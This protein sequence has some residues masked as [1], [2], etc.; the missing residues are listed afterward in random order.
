M[1]RK[2]GKKNEIKIDPLA[3]NICL[4][5]EP[6]IGK[7]QPIS[8]PVLL[9][10][11]WTPMGDVKVGDKI[12]GQDGKMYDVTG[13]FPQGVKDVYEITFSD[14]TKTRCGIEHLW[15]VHTKKQREN[16]RKNGDYRFVVKSLEEIIKDYKKEHQSNPYNSCHYKYSVPINSE[17]EFTQVEKLP[18]DPYILGLLLGDGGFTGS[19]VTF[20]S[21]E[22]ELFNQLEEELKHMGL[23]L[24][25]RDF[26]NH[27][28][29]T[30]IKE[31][32]NNSKNNILNTLLSELNLFGCDSRQKF[33]P[34]Q[35]I[36]S[37]IENRIKILSGIINTD[38]HIHEGISIYVCSYSEKLA[39]DV[40]ELARSLGFIAIFGNWDRTNES[41]TRKY[42]NEIEYRVTIIGDYSKLHLS[43]KHK[44][45]LKQRCWEYCKSIIDIQLVGQEESQCIMV[46]NPSNLYITNDYIV[47]H[48]TTIVKEMLEKLVGENGYMFLEMAGEAGADAISSIVYEDIDDWSDLEDI[49]EDIEY[50]KTTDYADLKAIV[51]DTYDGW[52]KL[53]EK[54]AIRLWNKNHPDKKADSIDA[55]WSGFQKGQS[56]AFE[57]MF[58][59]MVRLKK[60]GVSMIIIGHVKNKELT[61]I[62]TGIAYQT[63]TSDVE[64]IYFNLLKKKMHF[65][66]LAFYDR[67]I[68]TEKTGKKNI[69]TKKDETKNKVVEES[70]KI[71]F[72]DDNMALDSGSRFADI[73]EEIPL[74]SD[75]L[76]NALQDAIRA[77]HS[78]QPTTKSI[79]EV[80]KEQEIAKEQIV[81]KVATKKKEEIQQK[82]T[83]EEK[84]VLVKSFRTI[85][86]EVKEMPE[87][88]RQIAIKMKELELKTKELDDAPVEKVRDL[89]EFLETIR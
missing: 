78:K 33:I 20:T 31:E 16:M 84:E 44:N 29:A 47:T 80:K 10:D 24:N 61:D 12:Y 1:A 42:E 70:R 19:V 25:C 88:V 81:E 68:I 58:D 67:T 73:I 72:R 45:K 71:K 69:V 85:V 43:E 11:G 41:S 74:D 50:N 40:A 38:G 13:V 77:E 87:K 28:Q 82:N 35:Y 5:G 51:A 17:I 52:I 63:L 3:Y 8:E 76:I 9:K 39:K 53:A 55:A 30:I 59:I 7:E 62:A 37:S 21:P 26:E 15:H 66:G 22:E 89:V 6:K 86:D 57:L 54:E 60:I 27:K 2:Y 18:L 75:H 79:E 14:K 64:K 32:N 56:K 46:N 4:L 83:I 36:Y 65:I 48:N 23:Q 34:K 49:I